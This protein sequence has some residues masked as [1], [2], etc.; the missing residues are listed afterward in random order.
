[1]V[2]WRF[3]RGHFFGHQVRQLQS[4]FSWSLIRFCLFLTI[5]FIENSRLEGTMISNTVGVAEMSYRAG[6]LSGEIKDIKY[7]WN[8]APGTG[9]PRAVFEVDSLITSNVTEVSRDK[10]LIVRRAKRSGVSGKRREV[11]A[12]SKALEVPV[13][14]AKNPP[15][16][17]PMSGIAVASEEAYSVR[18]LVFGA[19]VNSMESMY[20]GGGESP[21]EANSQ[22]GVLKTAA[23]LSF[24]E[25]ASVAMIVENP[26][27][28]PDSWTYTQSI[29][30]TPPKGTFRW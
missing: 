27:E 10:N 29:I 2:V 24:L 8:S 15:R 14:L 11:A 17:W 25:V 1:M 7:Y 9:S 21:P 13:K 12:T 30:P 6:S 26:H 20:E 16:F 28:P 23:A 18:L 5:P 19:L 22:I 3:S 4:S